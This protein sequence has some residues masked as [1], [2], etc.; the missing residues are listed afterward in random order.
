MKTKFILIVIFLFVATVSFGQHLIKRNTDKHHMFNPSNQFITSANAVK[1]RLDSLMFDF[2]IEKKQIETYDDVTK[3]VKS[4]YYKWDNDTWETI[5]KTEYSFDNNGN[6]SSYIYYEA[7]EITGNLNPDEK[8]VLGYNESGMTI[9]E[10]VYTYNNNNWEKEDKEEYEYNAEGMLITTLEYGVT[11]GEWEL[12]TKEKLTYENGN[13]ISDI[14]TGWNG[15]GWHNISKY[16]YTYENGNLIKVGYYEWKDNTWSLSSIKECYYNSNN[17]MTEE[18]KYSYQ[19]G[20]KVNE[21]KSTRVFDNNHNIVMG[22]D[23][24]WGNDSWIEK[25]KSEYSYDMNYLLSDVILPYDL[26]LL[27]LY[28]DVEF[29]KNMGI[30]A[31]AYEKNGNEWSL[32]GT[33]MFY[34]SEQDVVSTK[35]SIKSNVKV[36]PNPASDYINVDIAGQANN[37]TLS[38][39]NAQGQVVLS[40]TIQNHEQINISNLTKGMYLYKISTNGNVFTGKICK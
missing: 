30:S 18:V 40:K 16:E 37:A 36:Y 13:L 34:Y 33:T 2:S 6:V 3:N 9:S 26:L 19:N 12:C 25:S 15:T 35:E 38:L 7:D 23:Y 21:F 1:M 24:Y 14:L 17:D 39:I 31:K 20:N 28:Y 4:E 10:E 11:D 22:I 32:V 5:C 27:F 8:Y 29:F